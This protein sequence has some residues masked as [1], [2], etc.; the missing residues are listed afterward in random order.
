MFLLVVSEGMANSSVSCEQ[1]LAKPPR[2]PATH[3]SLS[4]SKPFVRKTAAKES[5]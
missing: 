5:E 4:N 1:S 3:D 2:K